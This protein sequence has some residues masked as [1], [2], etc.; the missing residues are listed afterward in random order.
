MVLHAF[1]RGEVVFCI[2]KKLRQSENSQNLMRLSKELRFMVFIYPC[3]ILL[4][5]VDGKFYIAHVMFRTF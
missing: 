3:P 4:C 1:S 5:N 2:M